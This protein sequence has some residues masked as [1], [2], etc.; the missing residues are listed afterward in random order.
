MPY[1]WPQPLDERH[2][3]DDFDCG[4]PALGDWLKKHARGSHAS[5]AARVFV[6]TGE[7][8]KVAVG[9]Y[10]LA[11]AQVEPSTAT[12]R[13]GKGLPAHRPIPAVL[14]ARLAVDRRPQGAGLGTC[15]LQDAMLR[16][17]QAADAVGIRVL[18]VHAKEEAREWYLRYG[19][20]PSPTDEL[21]L[22]LLMKDLRAFVERQTS[23]P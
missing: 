7:D 10:A 20:E 2:E 11:A 18:L 16:C 5:G 8:G 1:S 13:A 23:S 15:L 3:L 4:V 19:V 14:L 21:H 9:Y 6:T 22:L 12:A 17:L